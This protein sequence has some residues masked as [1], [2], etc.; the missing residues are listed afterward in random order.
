MWLD[1]MMYVLLKICIRWIPFLKERDM[2]QNIRVFN[3]SDVLLCQYYFPKRMCAVS[4]YSLLSGASFSTTS[5]VTLA[6]VDI[7]ALLESAYQ[8]LS[9]LNE[10][11][12][13]LLVVLDV[14]AFFEN[15]E[16]SIECSAHCTF[17]VLRIEIDGLVAE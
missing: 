9:L 4:G 12:Y 17:T 5:H 2:L 15:W 6:S 11:G 14:L 3:G 16:H 1:I 13:H 10:V 8:L 7:F